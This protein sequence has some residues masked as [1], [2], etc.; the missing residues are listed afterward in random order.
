MTRR[1]GRRVPPPLPRREER[2][3]ERRGIFARVSPPQPA[4]RGR[5][6]RTPRGDEPRS[7]GLARAGRAILP[8]LG[9]RAGVRGKKRS[10]NQRAFELPMNLA[11]LSEGKQSPAP[12]K[13][14]S[15]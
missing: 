8:L 9:E 6:H 7:S 13:A 11:T 1:P 10:S 2:G 4:R 3:G 12:S 15:P 5:E 14:P